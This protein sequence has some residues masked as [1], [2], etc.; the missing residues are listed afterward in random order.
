M[1]K[2]KKT[3]NR[4]FVE[5]DSIKIENKLKPAEEYE[6]PLQTLERLFP[7]LSID[8]VESIYEDNDRNYYLTKSALEVITNHEPESDNNSLAKEENDKVEDINFS[9]I[10]NKR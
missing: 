3:K 10:K 4:R 6:T 5:L 2:N 9:Q 7:S 8:V 1:N